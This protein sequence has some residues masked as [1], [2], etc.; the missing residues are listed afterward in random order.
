MDSDG[1]EYQSCP[2]GS[3]PTG[4]NSSDPR[5]NYVNSYPVTS[6]KTGIT[7]TGPNI[8][9][10]AQAEL[11]V[12]GPNVGSN[13][14]LQTLVSGTVGAAA[15]AAHTAKIPSIAFSGAS[16]DPTAWNQPIPIH[17]KIYAA[18]ALNVTTTVI[19]SG[20]PYLPDDVFLNVNFGQVTDT[21]CNDPSDFKF[22]FTRVN[23]HLTN[24]GDVD[25]CG[26][27]W[28]PWEF[29]VMQRDGCYV[30]ISPGD[31]NDKSTTDATRQKTVLDKLKPIL[32][33][34]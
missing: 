4:S 16:G 22:V 19:N 14:A 7:T 28:L 21:K 26:S 30:A 2:A 31:A 23:A 18:L 17:S 29:T 1:C 11:A 24:P 10:G 12:S 15:Y 5:L 3:P 6:I 20:T 25:W 9:N 34:L 32:T 27:T 13:V 8:W 33:C